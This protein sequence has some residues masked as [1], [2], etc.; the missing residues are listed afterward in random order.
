MFAN[1]ITFSRLIL[2]FSILIILDYTGFYGHILS[3]FLM[4]VLI[5][6]D[7]VDGIV[8]R[9]FEKVT[10][11]GGVFDIVVDRIIENCI[12]IYFAGK[13]IISF[14]IPVIVLTRGL[15]I[16]GIRS[17]ALSKG[18]TAF[19]EKTLQKS[20]A[21][22]ILVNSHL[23]RGIYGISKMLSF[24]FLIV[25]QTLSFPETKS[26]ISPLW[27]PKIILTGHTIIYIT[28]AFCIL[29]GLPVL[30]DSWNFLF[31]KYIQHEI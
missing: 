30:L 24:L 11:F 29:R 26:F 21:G 10:D 19:G 4:A 16:D 27:H 2:L 13:G 5:V 8:A 31:S 6:L 7:A 22:K 3:L 12:W 17:V 15:L 25:I 23:S 9:F 1:L 20:I 14:W 18:M 28:V